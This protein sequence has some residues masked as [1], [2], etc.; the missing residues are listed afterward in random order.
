MTNENPLLPL[1]RAALHKVEDPEIR[2]PITELG[3]VDELTANDEGQI[4]IK[5]LLTVPGCPMRTEISNR[6]T[7]A[8]EAVEGVRGVHVEL[9]VMNDEQR[10]AMRQVLR[11]GQNARSHSLSQAI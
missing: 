3:M 4:F 6:V 2:R 5:V 11:G 9:G 10:S 1:V 8:V 7:E